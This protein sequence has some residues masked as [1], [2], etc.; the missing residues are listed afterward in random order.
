MKRAAAMKCAAVALWFCVAH[1]AL[2]TAQA[3][4]RVYVYNL[5]KRLTEDVVTGPYQESWLQPPDG[6]WEYEADL[7]VFRVGG[8]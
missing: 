6:G 3:E 2:L 1:S 8:L 4:P 7:W 5:P